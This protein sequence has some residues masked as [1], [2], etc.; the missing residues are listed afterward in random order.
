MSPLAMG[1]VVVGV[2]LVL[3]ATGMPIAFALGLVSIGAL[4]LTSGWGIMEIVGEVFF[5]GLA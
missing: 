2:L 3:L 5:G 1:S 4:I